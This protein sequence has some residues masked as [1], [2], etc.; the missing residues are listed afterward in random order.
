MKSKRVTDLVSKEI[1]L[2][3]VAMDFQGVFHDFM[4]HEFMY[5]WQFEQQRHCFKDLKDDELA[6]TADFAEKLGFQ[7]LRNV[8]NADIY[9]TF[10]ASLIF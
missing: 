2:S 7:V 3:D 10:L 6:S 4:K 5:K 9:P 1:N 8:S